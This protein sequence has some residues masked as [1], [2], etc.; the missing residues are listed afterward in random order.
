MV[1]TLGLGS[2]A[3]MRMGS[4]PVLGIII[5]PFRLVRLRTLPFQGNNVGSNPIKGTQA[6]LAQLEEQ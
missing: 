4:N 6:F 2:N 5:C 3:V 1:D